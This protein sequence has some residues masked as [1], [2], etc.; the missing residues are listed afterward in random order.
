[1]QLNVRLVTEP[2]TKLSMLRSGDAD[3]IDVGIKDVKGLQASGFQAFPSRGTEALEVLF[4]Y[5]RPD[6]AT[7]DINVRKA[8]SYALNR[9]EINQSFLAGLG[10]LTATNIQNFGNPL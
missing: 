6:E 9:E 1:K 5:F 8:L 4:Q 10:K 2:S 3:F 7:A